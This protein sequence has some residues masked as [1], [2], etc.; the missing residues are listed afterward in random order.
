M[1]IQPYV[2]NAI[3]HGLMNLRGER[4]AELSIRIR[5]D[6]EL[7]KIV[8]EDNGVG[9]ETAKKLARDFTH[10]SLGME[11]SRQ[12]LELMNQM[13]EEEKSSV[14]ITDLMDKKGNAC[15]TCVEITVRHNPGAEIETGE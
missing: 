3:W 9:R 7:L 8:V 5:G 2:E 6:G 15:G 4:N 11:L 10:K 12:R 13:P 1:L 14:F